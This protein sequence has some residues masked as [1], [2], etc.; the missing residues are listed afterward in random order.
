MS[1]D[2]ERQLEQQLEATQKQLTKISSL[3]RLS[4][5]IIASHD[6]KDNYEVIEL[7]A[8]FSLCGKQHEKDSEGWVSEYGDPISPIHKL[9]V[10]LKTPIGWK[11]CNGNFREEGGWKD[12]QRDFSSDD[13]V[14]IQYAMLEQVGMQGFAF[15]NRFEQK[16]QP[17]DIN[18]LYENLKKW[19][20]GTSGLPGGESD[21]AALA[22]EYMKRAG[23]DQNAPAT[24]A[25]VKPTPATKPPRT[26]EELWEIFY[27]RNK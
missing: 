4:F 12:V 9:C 14:S 7:M 23:I 1:S 20:A 13:L 11:I 5:N 18:K 19:S 22:K 10:A 25:K 26:A 27:G 2:Y 24:P 17:A 3:V 15:T 21:W 16:K 6:N 8:E